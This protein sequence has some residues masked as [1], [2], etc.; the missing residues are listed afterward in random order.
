MKT[1]MYVFL[2]VLLASFNVVRCQSWTGTYA[3]DD[4]CRARSCCCYAGTLSVT[5]SGSNLVFTSGTRGCSM[6]ST[7]AT[8]T[9]PRGNSFSTT[10]IRGAPITYTL[11][12]DG[13]TMTVRNDVN[14]QCGGSA[15]RTS[16][17]TNQRLSFALFCTT[18]F[19]LLLL[20]LLP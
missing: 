4:Q 15:R 6:S 10:G 3:W 14:S 11:S 16:V 18:L 19:T 2:A 5:R 13:N 8:F 1:L 20:L 17:G 9:Q 7:S 12:S